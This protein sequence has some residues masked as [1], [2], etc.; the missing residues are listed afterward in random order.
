MLWLTLLPSWISFLLIVGAAN[1]FAIAATLL[2]RRWYLRL[3]VTAG[4]AIV[5]AW[6]TTLGALAAVLCAFTIVTL[7]SIF[8]KAA[9]NNDNEAAAVRLAA[10]DMSAAQLPLLRHYVDVTARSWPRMCGGTPNPQVVAALSALE[11]DAKARSP[12]YANDLNRQLGTLEEARYQ[13]W[14]DSKSL[15]P[16][17]LKVALCII[18]VTLFGVLAIALPDRSDTHLALTVLV[19]TALGSVYW[20]MTA[21][22]YP[23]C[24]D[25]SIG[26][27]EIVSSMRYLSH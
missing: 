6:A 24:G 22:S 27:D 19:A 18:A 20:V 12:E 15:T 8:A 10:V 9:Q 7:W 11:R 14:Q 13:R 16:I 2:A 4:P 26:P 25:Y 23:Y 1:A 3:G 21:L 5:G 17:E